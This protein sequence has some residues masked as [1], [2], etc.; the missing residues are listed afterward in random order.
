MP[1]PYI[2]VVVAARND[3]HGGN[4][5]VRMRAFLNS[6][7]SQATR[8]DL[9]S[10]IV[11]V[12]WNP[13]ANRPPL[14][15][16]L[17]WPPD[18]RA[19][20][21]RFIGVSAEV[22]RQFRNHD[23]IPL[24]QMP[25]KNAGIRRAR[26]EFVLAT[27]LDVV[28]SSELMQFFAERGLEPRRMYRID[29]NDVAS[30]V[31]SDASVEELLAFCQSH[32]LRVFAREGLF[33]FASDG[34]RVLDEND[35][36]APDAGIRFGA[37]CFPVE[38]HKRE[39][40]RWIENRAEIVLQ[41]KPGTCLSIDAEVGPSAGGEPVALEV[42]DAD[43]RTLASAGVEGRC[44]LL[45]RMP[46]QI[47]ASTLRLRVCGGGIPLARDARM[48]N[49]R[50]FGLRW[51]DDGTSHISEWSLEVVSTQP[52]VP[53]RSSSQAPSPFAAQMRDAEF[54]HTNACGDFTLL[55][56]EDWFNLRGYPEFP[57]WPMHIDA[58]FC[59]AAHHAGVREMILREPMRMF[60]IQHSS[61]AGWTPEGEA[62]RSA[63][64][65][66]KG[67]TQVRYSDW[68]RWV[69]QMRRFNAPMIFTPENWGLAGIDLPESYRPS[70][71]TSRVLR[72]RT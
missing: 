43:G 39:P 12:E 28:F 17:P 50:L 18:T 62:E 70:S 54:L 14:N 38:L 11:V 71:N 64:I 31:P 3:D 15:D 37:G 61:G 2:S 63:R 6:W 66:S 24:H 34:L 4:M 33:Q 42:V 59:Y 52:G 13:P 57:I 27:N 19:C 48:L 8:Y 5:L 36:A 69:D 60:H 23:S 40:F 72:S 58:L 9:P 30:D 46:A 49:L 41:K 44:E 25:A 45:L 68:V 21:V 51:K 56:R 47:P 16:C 32:M 65:E 1:A 29:R 53:W 10:E 20:Q 7:I 22:H 67:V 26:G 35:I 55:S